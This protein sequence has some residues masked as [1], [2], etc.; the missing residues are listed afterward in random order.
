MCLTWTPTFAV[1]TN[2]LLGGSG[3]DHLLTQMMVD[4]A[5]DDGLIIL[6]ACSTKGVLLLANLA[7]N[8]IS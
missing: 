8:F 7:P 3:K 5:N 4:S 1:H 6:V 2:G